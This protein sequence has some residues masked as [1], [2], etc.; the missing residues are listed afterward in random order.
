MKLNVFNQASDTHPEGA[1]NSAQRS[2]GNVFFT[3]PNSTDVFRVKLG[4]FGQFLLARFNAFPPITD[5]TAREAIM[6]V[7]DV[8]W[9]RHCFGPQKPCLILR[10]GGHAL[11]HFT[12]ASYQP[13]GG[14]PHNLKILKIRLAFDGR[15]GHKR[16]QFFKKFG[17]CV[18]LA[19]TKALEIPTNFPSNRL[20]RRAPSGAPPALSVAG[21]LVGSLW[22]STGVRPFEAPVWG[23]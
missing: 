14:L 8:S 20:A 7:V 16:G 21:A 9:K 11:R 10:L 13:L 4:F 6:R 12:M 23:A 2:H 17:F 1:G 15:L 3:P 22:R 18:A 19:A 5:G